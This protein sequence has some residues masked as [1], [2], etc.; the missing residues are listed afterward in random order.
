[1]TTYKHLNNESNLLVPS[2][3]NLELKDLNY[4][5]TMSQSLHGKPAYSNWTVAQAMSQGLTANSVVFAAAKRIANAVSSIP[6]YVEE[7]MEGSDVW[8]KS[9]DSRLQKLLDKPTEFHTQAD[10]RKRIVYDLIT[11]G[12]SLWGKGRAKLSHTNNKTEITELWWIPPDCI[13]PIC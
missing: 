9:P 11:S 6:L 10:L 7:S 12:N 1:M 2:N 5:D 13:K 3:Y 4:M 8:T